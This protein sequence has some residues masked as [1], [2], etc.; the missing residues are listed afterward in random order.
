M[1]I[2]VI[3]LGVLL[4]TIIIVGSIYFFGQRLI[5]QLT[6][7]NNE[8]R[9]DTK[10]E[11]ESGVKGILD[12]NQKLLSQ[13]VKGL[14]KQLENNRKDVGDIKEQN[15][16]IREQLQNTAEITK[17]LQVSTESLK[18]LLSNN[19]LRGDWGE[20]IAEDLLQAAGFVEK[21]NYTKQTTVGSG[22]PDFTILLPDGYKLNVDAKFPF[23]DLIA[24]QNAETADDKKRALNNF[25]TTVK[26][27]VKEISTRDYINPEE[28]TLDFVIMFIPNEM[29]FSFI[30]EKVADI[31]QYANE[32]KV[33]LAGPFGFTAVL[34]LIL[35]AHKNFHHE[36]SLMKILGLISKFQD[37]YDK[38][39]GALEKLGKQIDTT[40]NTF[41][42]VEGTRSR[43]LSR[44][45]R[46]ISEHS[47][48]SL[49]E[50]KQKALD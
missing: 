38:F 17:G 13:V 2:A 34:R 31:N 26:S 32:H 8:Q 49:K 25:R 23:D 7:A 46:Q 48:N 28:Q 29:I 44:V 47:E 22:R 33:I 9:K 3:V 40:K 18:N 45:V 24:Y 15:V 36:K 5:L 20:Q 39:G 12:N 35:Q 50:E 10:N 11:I 4:A 16:A 43:Q 41:V 14:E 1:I 19:R 27:K 37:E 30:Y 21:I 42:E 6:T